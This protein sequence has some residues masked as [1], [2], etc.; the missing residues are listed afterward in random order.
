MIDLSDHPQGD[1]PVRQRAWGVFHKDHPDLKAESC[2]PDVKLYWF[3]FRHHD[4]DL[5]EF[6]QLLLGPHSILDFN[7]DRVAGYLQLNIDGYV[8]SNGRLSPEAA[9]WVS[10][11]VVP[12][13]ISGVVDLRPDGTKYI[14]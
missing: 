12:G 10:A 9:R 4:V 11:H 14:R 1:R 3:S 7:H 5:E 2:R 6:E 8:R 13:R